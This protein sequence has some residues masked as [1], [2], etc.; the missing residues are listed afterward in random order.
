MIN[1][2]TKQW[3]KKIFKKIDE[4]LTVEAKRLGGKIPYIPSAETG[5]YEEDLGTSDPVWWTNGFW[6]GMMWQMYH[7]TEKE[8]YKKLLN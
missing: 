4:K 2:E 3:A 1:E 8:L 7:A 5:L 6:S